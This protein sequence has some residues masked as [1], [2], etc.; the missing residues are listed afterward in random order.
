MGV[1]APSQ[2]YLVSVKLLRK[3]PEEHVLRE[4]A[5]T[6]V[7]QR[8]LDRM[9][10]ERRTWAGDGW[11]EKEKEKAMQDSKAKQINSEQAFSFLM[12]NQLQKK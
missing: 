6:F 12:P 2:L 7:D 4:K 10:I 8:V 11:K 1:F 5:K 9:G 3:L